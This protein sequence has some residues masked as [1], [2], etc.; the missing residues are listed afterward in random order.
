[1]LVPVNRDDSGEL[2]TVSQ[3]C[4]ISN[5]G[6]STVRRIARESGAIRRIGKCY[7]IRREDFM[8]YIDSQCAANPVRIDRII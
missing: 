3:T 7:R 4:R 6:Q 1:M 5:L 8:N 2:L